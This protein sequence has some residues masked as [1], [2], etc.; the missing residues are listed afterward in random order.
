MDGVDPFPTI[1]N[2]SED[3]YE[4]ITVADL[5][6]EEF[7]ENNSQHLNMVKDITKMVRI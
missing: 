5:Q 2:L 7:V 1:K 4:D 3:L 6:D